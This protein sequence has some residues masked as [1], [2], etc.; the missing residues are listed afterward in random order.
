MPCVSACSKNKV[1]ISYS[2]ITLNNSISI[3]E[4][5]RESQQ[6][7]EPG[8]IFKSFSETNNL[9]PIEYRVYTTESEF[10]NI[11][12]SQTISENTSI[13]VVWD[14]AD[15]N[16]EI[17]NNLN[18]IIEKIKK[19]EEISN[20]YNKE[21]NSTK[22]ATLR[23]LQYIRQA[24]YVGFEWGIVAGTMESDFA[25]YVQQHQGEINLQSLQSIQY[26]TS[27]KTKPNKN[28]DVD[29]VHMLA[30]VNVL[31]YG[32]L[33][34]ISCNDLASWGGDICQLAIELKDTGFTGTELQEYADNMFNNTTS[35]YSCYDVLANADAFAIAKLH[36]DLNQQSIATTFEYYYKLTNL[37]KRNENFLKI[38][39]PEVYENNNTSFTQQDL[40]DIVYDRVNNNSLIGVWCL[41]QGLDINSLNSQL[42]ACALSFAKYYLS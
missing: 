28:N 12:P 30:V 3:N 7:V 22:D 2:H 4:L 5:P 16:Q 39:F 29:F 36:K 8:Y 15:Y 6:K 26:F 10:K 21:K 18:S 25:S 27:P 37:D 41:K 19:L 34:N 31:L 17:Y 38:A 23:V 42:K 35:S 33:E 14:K 11:Y 9:K 13:V 1:N 40:A 24:R 20:E 32:S